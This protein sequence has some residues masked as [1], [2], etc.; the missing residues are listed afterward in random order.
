MCKRRDKTVKIAG[1]F[2]FIVFNSSLLILI[3]LSILLALLDKQYEF[4]S[5]PYGFEDEIGVLTQII[6]SLASLVVSIV[7]I[8]ISLQNEEFFGTKISRLYA[9]RVTQHY[10]ILRIILRSIMLCLVN[11]V[12]YMLGLTVAAISTALATLSF[13]IYVLCDEVPIMSKN[14]YA[15]LSIIKDNLI[16]SY[17]NKQEVPKDLKDVI[18][19]LL[20]RRNLKEIYIEFR[21]IDD[22]SYNQYLLLK[23]LEFQHDL[24]FDLNDQYDRKEQRII[25]S[26]MTEN[27]FDIIFR[28]ID[29]TDEQYAD[30]LNNKHLITRVLFRINEN[31]ST[32]D[33][34][35]DRIP[36]LFQCLSFKSALQDQTEEFL[37]HVLII[38]SS[39]T[40][41]DKDFGVLKGIRR[42][43]SGSDYCLKENTAA[44]TVFTVLS[45]HLFYLC[46]SEPDTPQTVKE[47]IVDF[48]NEQGT[49]EENTRI[50]SWK[51]LFKTVSSKFDVDYEKFINLSLKNEHSLE[52]YLYG[53]H[54][55]FVVLDQGY[56]T[57]WYLTHLLNAHSRYIFNFS[58][59]IVKYPNIKE[60]LKRFGETCFDE[61][62]QFTPTEQMKSIVSFYS[63]KDTH[64]SHFSIL[65]SREHNFF[66]TMNN[67]KLE[68]LRSE[69][70]LA[71]KV[72]EK[73]LAAKIKTGIEETVQ[74]EWG[75]SPA[76]PIDSS[77]RYFAV[78]LEKFPEAINFEDSIIDFGKRSV[79]YDIEKAISKT[80]IYNDDEFDASIRQLLSQ[81]LKYCTQSAKTIIHTYFIK[82]GEL[83]QL[84]ADACNTLQE[85]DSNLLNH[86]ALIADKGFAFNCEVSKVFF[87]PLSEEELAKE[88]SKHQRADGQYVF[89][90][91]FVPQEEITKMIRDKFTVLMITI[92]YS[93]ISSENSIFE[94]Y[95]YNSG[96][97][98]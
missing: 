69:V 9:L 64:F 42:Q 6:T 75:Y 74:N 62:G 65:E 11:L 67:I 28:H 8:A 30:I 49:I 26:S 89:N 76:L 39:V 25:A 4:F 31:P 58:E 78:L 87:R 5:W 68:T 72:D 33:I 52:Y 60:R 21:D 13:L 44:L 79:L 22:D 84:Y 27:I 7:G 32:R 10:S 63:D 77:E 46:H 73:L 19:Y 24:A 53:I 3:V 14:E 29:I 43:L 47:A 90:G 16:L 1:N 41:K 34:L 51:K 61:N 18:R 35:L 92:R 40:V 50:V 80:T 20:Y 88:V 94:I 66:N 71:M 91:A 48:I 81:K 86:I 93:I 54:A 57:N 97:E 82:D 17:L 38:L 23:L 95:P 36:G 15:L 55:K 2:R 83:K 12:C 98:E 56:L 59:L 37:S 45:M 70:E 96:P 85:F